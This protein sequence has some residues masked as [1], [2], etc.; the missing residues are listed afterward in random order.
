MPPF[1]GQIPPSMMPAP[2]SAGPASV[3]HGNPGQTGAGIAQVRLGLEALQ[4][5]LPTIPMGTELHNAIID[6][7]K[8]IGA[9]MTE[10]VQGPQQQMQELL[11]M[12]QQAKAQQPHAALAGIAG[13]GGGQPPQPPMLAPPPG[14]PGMQAAA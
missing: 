13:G 14:P 5:A 10:A 2:P 1:G 3:P 11:Q 7:V 4:K 12:V 8:K 6:A 9:H